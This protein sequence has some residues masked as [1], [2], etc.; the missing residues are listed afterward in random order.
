MN[1]K[2]F[3]KYVCQNMDEE[4]ELCITTYHGWD[5]FGDDQEEVVFVTSYFNIN[6]ELDEDIFDSDLFHDNKEGNKECKKIVTKLK[7]KYSKW[8][9]EF[10]K[11][12]KLTINET[13]I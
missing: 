6:D 9:K 8:L 12:I 3:R 7:A 11:D 10:N 2:E 5:G 13:N 1:L 4:L